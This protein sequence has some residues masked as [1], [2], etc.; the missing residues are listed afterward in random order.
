MQGLGSLHIIGGKRQVY[1]IFPKVIGL[2]VV[3]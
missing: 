3:L 1:L 2:W